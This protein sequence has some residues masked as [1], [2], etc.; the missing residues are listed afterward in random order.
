M[1]RKRDLDK[2]NVL[3]TEEAKRRRLERV[4]TGYVKYIHPRIYQEAHQFYNNLHAAY[5]K[6]K[7]LRKTHEFQQLKTNNFVLRIPLMDCETTLKT[8]AQTTNV[9]ETSAQTTNVEETS[10]QTINVQETSAQTINVLETSAQT[11]NVLE[12]SAQTINVQET[13]AQT[14]NV[15]ETSAQTINVQE[16]SAPPLS[17]TIPAETTT[18]TDLLPIDDAVLEQIMADLRQDPCIRDFFD[19]YDFEMDDCPLW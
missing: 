12:T 11:I 6:K 9:E 13:S 4:L 14:I 7:D 18:T 15:L 1:S 10:A 2:E 17:G 8:S 16:T 5:P 19:N 3:R